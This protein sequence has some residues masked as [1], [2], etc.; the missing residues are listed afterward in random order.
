MAIW[1]EKGR[2][3]TA[4]NAVSDHQGNRSLAGPFTPG[5]GGVLM[6]RTRVYPHITCRKVGPECF[7]SLTDLKITI[8]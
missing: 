4:F 8:C 6:S 5:G 2:T 7:T 3:N 1:E